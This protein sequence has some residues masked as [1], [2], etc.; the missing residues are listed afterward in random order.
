MTTALASPR[1]IS[2]TAID[3]TVMTTMI[4]KRRNILPK[5]S[6]ATNQ[7][8]GFKFS[9]L[10]L[11]ITNCLDVAS[12]NSFRGLNKKGKARMVVEMTKKSVKIVLINDDILI[13]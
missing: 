10:V 2:A 11:I 8:F 5:T 12:W 1:G 9:K 6:M 7:L 3:T 4:D 13:T